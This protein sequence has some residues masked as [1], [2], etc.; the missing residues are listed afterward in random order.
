MQTLFHKS[1]AKKYQKFI[2]NPE[3]I[4]LD[5][6]FKEILPL[7]V[8]KNESYKDKRSMLEAFLRDSFID[9]SGGSLEIL[10][11]AL[12]F[13]LEIKEI[14]RF[15]TYYFFYIK[16]HS[17]IPLHYQEAALLFIYLKKNDFW[18]SMYFSPLNI[19]PFKKSCVIVFAINM[20][21]IPF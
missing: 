8:Y 18:L 20:N 12:Q 13:S 16:T 11:L 3:E 5:S 6:E 4:S 2:N 17:K 15:W 10:E 21:S 14:E 1:W 7:L 19:F 9:L